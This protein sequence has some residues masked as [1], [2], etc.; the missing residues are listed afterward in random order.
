MAYHNLAMASVI[1]APEWAQ[2]LSIFQFMAPVEDEWEREWR[3]VQKHPVYSIPRT[4][5]DAVAQVSP[6]RGWAKVVNA[7]KPT[8]AAIVALIA[9]AG[10]SSQLRCALPE[11]FRSVGI[12]EEPA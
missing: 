4:G 6:P 10:C 12:T 2:L 8:S 5:S 3:I 9:P 11:S 1:G 7:L